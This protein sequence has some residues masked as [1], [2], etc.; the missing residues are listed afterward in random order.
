MPKV[1]RTPCLF[2]MQVGEGR[3]I[4]WLHLS[5]LEPAAIQ[6]TLKRSRESIRTFSSYFLYPWQLIISKYPN[7]VINTFTTQVLKHLH[8]FNSGPRE[9]QI[10][11][12][13]IVVIF[14]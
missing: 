6:F 14:Y 2:K 10:I 13:Y 11:M 1:C 12:Y 3:K 4:P 7:L 5:S 9:W 8:V